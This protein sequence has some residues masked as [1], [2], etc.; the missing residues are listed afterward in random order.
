[1]YDFSTPTSSAASL[2]LPELQ[3]VQQLNTKFLRREVRSNFG[4]GYNA[5]HHYLDASTPRR[6]LQQIYSSRVDKTCYPRE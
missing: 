3:V 4:I 6:L 1:M 2:V 5:I